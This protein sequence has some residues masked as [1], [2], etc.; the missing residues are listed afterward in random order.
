MFLLRLLFEINHQKFCTLCKDNLFCTQVKNQ[1]EKKEKKG[2]QAK[3]RECFYKNTPH[4][5]LNH[6]PLLFEFF[7]TERACVSMMF[8]AAVRQGLGETLCQSTRW[9]NG[10]KFIHR[11]HCNKEASFANL[12]QDVFGRLQST[13]P[14]CRRS[15]KRS[16]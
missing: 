14:L 7:P 13:K 16:L 6:L 1:K 2:Q 10:P 11:S 5:C 9:G 3:T 4:S 12:F 8:A 15:C